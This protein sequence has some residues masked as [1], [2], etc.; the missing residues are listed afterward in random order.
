MAGPEKGQLELLSDRNSVLALVDY[1]PS[2]FK[3]VASGD[4]TI[5][6]SEV[7]QWRPQI[8]TSQPA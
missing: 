4:K 2:M 8:Y 5:I 3:G 6:K 1:Q 7:N